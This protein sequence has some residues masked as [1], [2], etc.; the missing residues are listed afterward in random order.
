MLGKKDLR[1]CFYHPPWQLL[2]LRLGWKDCCWLL[3]DHLAISTMLY[4]FAVSGVMLPTV[5]DPHRIKKKGQAWKEVA[6]HPPLSSCTGGA[7]TAAAESHCCWT[8]A[9]TYVRAGLYL[10][11][12]GRRTCADSTTPSYLAVSGGLA[13]RVWGKKDL[14]CCFYHPPLQLL[15]LR[16]GWKDCCYCWLVLDLL[17][18]ST[19]LCRSGLRVTRAKPPR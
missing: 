13:G 14:R 3:Q 2:C 19:M 1:C 9:G 15:C 8:G 6:P 16:L 18:I 17:A 10:Y 4:S 11:T 7:P 12:F 5:P